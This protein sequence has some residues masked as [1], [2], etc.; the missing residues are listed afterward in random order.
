MKRNLTKILFTIMFAF[1]VVFVPGTASNSETSMTQHRQ[2]YSLNRNQHR[3]HDYHANRDGNVRLH[4]RGSE[5]ANLQVHVLNHGREVADDHGDSC[6]ISFHAERGE[7]YVFKVH[8]RGD[9]H[10]DYELWTE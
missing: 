3:N 6:D 2:R 4:V 8:N 1:T 7:E 10:C 9:H 5:H